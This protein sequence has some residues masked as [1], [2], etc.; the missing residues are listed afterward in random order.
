MAHL[1]TVPV[2]VEARDEIE[3]LGEHL[4]L[5]DR[6]FRYDP[7]YGVAMLKVSFNLRPQRWRGFDDI[8]KN[9][10]RELDVDEQEL[11]QFVTEHRHNLEMACKM[12]GI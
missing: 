5:L 4:N 3:S 12:I 6:D 7:L 8:L 9:T 11:D 1:N 10:L 2:P